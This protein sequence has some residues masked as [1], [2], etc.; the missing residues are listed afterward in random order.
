MNGSDA[1]EFEGSQML[2]TIA[3]SKIGNRLS[4]FSMNRAAV[5]GVL[6]AFAAVHCAPSHVTAGPAQQQ[7]SDTSGQAYYEGAFT[8]I[9]LPAGDL[10]E[11][12]PDLSGLVPAADQQPLPRLLSEVGK[13]VE[14]A[15]QKFTEVIADEQVSRVQCG[16]AGRLRTIARQEFTYLIIPHHEEGLDRIEEYR[17]A[18][19][20]KPGQSLDSGALSSIGFA[21]MWALFY[22]G[23]QFESRFR[24]LGQQPFGERQANVI[25]FAQRPGWSSVKGLE[26]PQ[27]VGQPVVV[28]YQGVVW[29]DMASNKILK[30][31][32]ELLK[33]RL[34][35]KLELQTIEIRFG[36]VHVSDAA[37]TSL[38][39]P[40]QVTVTTVWNGQ[41]LR[42]EHL[43]SN[44][45]L[46]GSNTKIQPAPAETLPPPKTN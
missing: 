28:L 23:N 14:E 2:R 7:P 27:P 29:L 5:A 17:T 13:N 19:G 4:T 46:P 21:A 9:D 22:P 41:V 33:P 15:Y 32:A 16:P 24:Y 12:L 38:W 43:Y 37:S 44:Y 26:H 31:Q 39:V 8:L 10:V 35:I 30:M 6:I 25:G 34:D 11:A 45:K 20:G 36:E 3:T 18:L 1:L 40:L 42:D